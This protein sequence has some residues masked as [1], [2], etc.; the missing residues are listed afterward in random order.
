VEAV[1]YQILV[2]SL[3]AGGTALGAV[4]AVL[5]LAYRITDNRH[6]LRLDRLSREG[7]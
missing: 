4:G 1:K 3:I 6:R 7:I 5:A 2:M